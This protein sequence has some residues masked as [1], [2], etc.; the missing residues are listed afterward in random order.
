MKK[1]NVKNLLLNKKSISVLNGVNHLYGRTMQPE[2]ISC[3]P[4]GICCPTHD[5]GCPSNTFGDTGNELT[6]DCHTNQA[7]CTVPTLSEKLC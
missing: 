3:E 5:T 6:V 7:G 2:T 4:F 1:Q